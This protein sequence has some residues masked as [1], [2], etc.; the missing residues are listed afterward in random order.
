MYGVRSLKA[1]KTMAVVLDIGESLT[2]VGFAGE[3]L[4]RH[5]IPTVFE[6]PDGSKLVDPLSSG[7][8]RLKVTTWIPVLHKLMTSIYFDYLQVNPKDRRVIICENPFLLYNFR[9]A[10]AKVL[11]NLEVPGVMFLPSNH[12]PL[13]AT[14]QQHALVVDVGFSE[15]RVTPI[16]DGYVIQ[17]AVLTTPV[18]MRNITRK[19]KET[20]TS[21][22][23]EALDPRVN[24]HVIENMV[25]RTAFVQQVPE[26]RANSAIQERKE[27]DAAEKIEKA[28]KA[29]L[30][31]R[32]PPTSPVLGGKRPPPPPPKAE[33]PFPVYKDKPLPPSVEYPLPPNLDEPPL[34]LAT[35]VSGHNS[36]VIPGKARALSAEALFGENEEGFNIADVVLKSLTLCPIDARGA[37]IQNLLICGGTSLLPGFSRR[38][39]D[40]INVSLY[41]KQWLSLK[42]LQ[43]KT[44]ITP[45]A[46]HAPP[47]LLVWIAG[48][49]IGSIDLEPERFETKE[50]FNKT[51]KL[52]DWS[53]VTNMS[54]FL[55]PEETP[56]RPS[57]TTEKLQ[58]V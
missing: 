30:S 25:L 18:G 45:V 32:Q 5:V 2:K 40:E 17:N 22:S 24:D 7:S 19:F 47:H 49:L 3:P 28:K 20:L 15:T 29:Q 50:G 51:K 55:E 6:R 52:K 42:A 11:F 43:Y 9:T 23:K 39:I 21:E 33:A 1:L 38:L 14:G 31:P 16:C 48:S 10:L 4:P 8:Q 26:A 53:F 44:R 36:I 41:R 57:T 46:A 56:L 27:Q 35:V 58:D 34:A 37:V 54:L 12:L 13:F